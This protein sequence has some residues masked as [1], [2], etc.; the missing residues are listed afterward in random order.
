MHNKIVPVTVAL[1]S[2]WLTSVGCDRLYAGDLSQGGLE[3]VYTFDAATQPG[4]HELEQ[5]VSML[6]H[7]FSLL[8][9]A[10]LVRPRPGPPPAVI[11]TVPAAL[12]ASVSQIKAIMAVTGRLEF[13]EVDD[14]DVVRALVAQ[15]P[16]DAEVRLVEEPCRDGHVASLASLHAPSGALAQAAIARYAAAAKAK[17]CDL[18]LQRD[19]DGGATVFAVRPNTYQ[20]DLVED[21]EVFAQK[22]LGQPAVRVTFTREGSYYFEEITKRLIGRKLAIVIDDKVASAPLVM[23]AIGGGRA[24]ITL[25]QSGNAKEMELEAKNLV[26]AL[27][28]GALPARLTLAEEHQIAPAK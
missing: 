22:E 13:R 6:S 3:L 27:R 12:N 15:A 8:S 16:P 10:I 5:T 26:V 1:L 11:I 23:T 21:A 20:G 17:G 18:L 4:A 19:A 28:V 24:I 7:R 2:L 14:G 9:M 25:P